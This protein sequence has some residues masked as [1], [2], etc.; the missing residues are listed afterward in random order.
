M[1]HAHRDRLIARRRSRQP[2][3][4]FEIHTQQSAGCAEPE[5]PERVFS[6]LQHG[7]IE[8]ADMMADRHHSVARDQ[9]Q[10]GGRADPEIAGRIAHHHAR[11][12]GQPG[13]RADHQLTAVRP[14]AQQT[15]P[16]AAQPERPVRIAVQ[17]V[18]RLSHARPVNGCG[19]KFAGGGN[20]HQPLR[21][22]GQNAQL[23]IVREGENRM[24]HRHA[25][26]TLRN[27]R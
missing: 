7:V 11:I 16:F 21:R 12:T 19:L 15:K 3:K 10:A 23:G 6:D 2:F 20:T 9:E 22:A 13:L 26:I 1:Q 8:A 17:A 18:H 14:D 5:P 24:Y 4:V 25:V 27:Q